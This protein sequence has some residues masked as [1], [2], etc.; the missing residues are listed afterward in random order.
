MVI[1]PHAMKNT[2]LPCCDYRVVSLDVV[3]DLVD[4]DVL[5]FRREFSCLQR[6][7]NRAPGV[8]E[9]LRNGGMEVL[10]VNHLDGT[11]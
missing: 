1:G 7:L 4:D 8:E 11:L 2:Q 5:L 6:L 10:T 9:L 3:V